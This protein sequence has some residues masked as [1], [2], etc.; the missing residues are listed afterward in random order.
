MVAVTG[1]GVN[2]APALRK[3]DV[4]VSMGLVGTDVAKEAA[5]TF[6]LW[7]GRDRTKYVNW[8]LAGNLM[9]DLAAAARKYEIDPQPWLERASSYYAEAIKRYPSS[10]VLHAQLA[11]SAALERRW[12]ACQRAA[13]EA[14]RL[15]AATPHEDKKLSSQLLWLPLLPENATEFGGPGPWVPAEPF[16]AWLRT[17]DSGS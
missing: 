15:S 10:A 16:I 8:Q 9:L 1:D 6:A 17:Q 13:Q 3:A 12:S 4:G 2:D 14:L 11:A 7:L 5:D